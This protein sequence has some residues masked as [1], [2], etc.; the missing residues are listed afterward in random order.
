MTFTVPVFHDVGLVGFSG[1]M[2][3]WPDVDGTLDGSTTDIY[4]EGL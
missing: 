4:S 2:A 3:H 1:C